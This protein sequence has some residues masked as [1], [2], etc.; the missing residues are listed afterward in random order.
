MYKDKKKGKF[1]ESQVAFSSGMG[2]RP[3][4]NSDRFARVK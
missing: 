3:V 2:N 1:R 4:M